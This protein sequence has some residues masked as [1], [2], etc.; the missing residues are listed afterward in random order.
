M[1][2]MFFAGFAATVVLPGLTDGDL[3]MLTIVR[4]TFPPWFLGIIGGAGAFTGDG[5]GS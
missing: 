1:P 4:K 5:S 3:S 2:W